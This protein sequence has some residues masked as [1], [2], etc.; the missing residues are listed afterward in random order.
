[1]MVRITLAYTAG[2]KHDRGPRLCL[3]WAANPWLCALCHREFLMKPH[4]KLDTKGWLLIWYID[5]WSAVG[6]IIDGKIKL[7]CHV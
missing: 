4:F 1:M 3:D 2:G 6:W 5:R 7:V